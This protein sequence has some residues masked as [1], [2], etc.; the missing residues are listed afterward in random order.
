MI[1]VLVKGHNGFYG[2]SDVLR[3]FY[4]RAVENRDEGYITCEDE[5]D[6]V[7]YSV[8]ENNK[9]STFEGDRAYWEKAIGEKFK[10]NQLDVKREIKR[11][12]YFLLSQIENKTFPWG[13]LTG[14]R[15]TLVAN[16]VNSKELLVLCFLF[17]S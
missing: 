1:K 16:E 3:L 4:G 6:I 11:Q 12:L 10:G 17:L 9:V 5:K 13:S 2:L 7:I 15:P 8:F 14:I